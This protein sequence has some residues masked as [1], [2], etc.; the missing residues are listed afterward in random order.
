MDLPDDAVSYAEQNNFEIKAYG[1]D[2]K[3]EVTRQPRI[4]RIGAIQNKVDVPTTAP[5]TEQ[6]AALHD[7]IKN[8]IYTAFICGVNVVCLQEAWSRLFDKMF[9]IN[10]TRP[11]SFFSSPS[12]AI[13][14][15]Y[16]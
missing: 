14:L 11:N 2:A 16:S 15:L 9:P 13:C 5:V 8:M 3:Y 1:F 12:H 10:D 7:K 4:V 6:R